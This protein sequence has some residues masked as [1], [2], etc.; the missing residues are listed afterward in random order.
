MEHDGK[1]LVKDTNFKGK[2]CINCALKVN[3]CKSITMIIFFLILFLI[4]AFMIVLIVMF[5]DETR[6]M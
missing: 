2:V 1:Y 5:D 3:Y 6:G 4:L